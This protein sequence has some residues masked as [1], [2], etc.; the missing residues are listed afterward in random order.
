MC[1][2]VCLCVCVRARVRARARALV[3]HQSISAPSGSCFG[4]DGRGTES[5]EERHCRGQYRHGVCP[6]SLI[7]LFGDGS[8]SCGSWS[9]KAVLA[10]TDFLSARSHSRNGGRRLDLLLID[11]SS[12]PKFSE[13]Q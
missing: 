7:L 12:T 11:L 1:V 8:V 13:F 6:F 5:K 2:S 3:Y 4:D 10:F 9:Q